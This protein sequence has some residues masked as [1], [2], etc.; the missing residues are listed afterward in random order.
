[1]I[2]P[3]ARLGRRL[4]GLPLRDILRSIQL[5]VMNADR[6]QSVTTVITILSIHHM[7]IIRE[8]L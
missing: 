1:M 4:K 2:K 6:L 5:L 7:S 3:P 8:W